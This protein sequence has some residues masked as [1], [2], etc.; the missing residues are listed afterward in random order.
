MSKG[1]RYT[2]EFKAK[3]VRLL[4]ESRPSY[5]SE[6][7]AI[8]E[9]AR[10][11]GVSS[12]TLR[13]WRNQS[14]A[15]AAEQSEQSA[16][17][18]M[19]ELKRLRAEN[20]ELRRANEIL[21]TA[22]A[23]SRRGSTRHGLDGRVHRRASGSFRGR[24][25]PQGAGR[26]VGLRVSHAARLPHVQ[27]QAAQPHEGAPRGAGPGHPPDP[28]G[29]LHGRVRIQ[30]G[31]CPAA[32]RGVGSVRGRPRP[33]DEHHA[34]ARHTRRQARQDAGDHQA[35]EGRGRQARP[36]GAQVPGHGAEPAAR[37]RHHLRAHD[38]R[39]VRLRCVR[40]RRIRPPHRGMGVRHQHEHRGAAPAGAGAGDLL[41]RGARRHPG[42]SSTTATTAPSTSARCTPRACAS[43]GCCPRPARSATPTTT[44]WPSPSTAR[45]RPSWSG[46][47]SRSGTWATWSWRRSNGSHGGTRNASTPAWTTGHPSRSKP[48]TIRTRRHKPPHYKGGTLIMVK[49]V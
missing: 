2:D 34:R 1:T 5:S 27:D 24:A 6:T 29:F 22:S 28:F 44:P 26:G 18:A 3:A 21:T 10:D 38:G 25:D 37:G 32:R 9:V 48:S 36:R 31:P 41:G 12:E 46:G 49:P 15:S 40:H 11:P 43:T 20:A 14:D 47:A 35:G 30:E 8:A 17:E 13:R 33:G 45:T 42:G 4:T 19:A 16:Q 7:K 23:F 39:A